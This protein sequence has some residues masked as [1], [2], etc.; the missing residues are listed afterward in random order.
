MSVADNCFG[1]ISMIDSTPLPPFQAG[2]RLYVL[3]EA[4]AI[5]LSDAGS[6]LLIACCGNDRYRPKA[7]LKGSLLRTA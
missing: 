7:V 1:E 4:E 5:K 3:G 2:L 6:A